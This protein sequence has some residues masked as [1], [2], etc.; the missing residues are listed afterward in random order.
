MHFA[1]SKNTAGRWH[2]LHEHLRAVGDLSGRFA[3]LAVWAGEAR[4]AGQLHDLGKYAERRNCR[5]TDGGRITT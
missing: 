2:P 1:H 4:L 3:A 5:F